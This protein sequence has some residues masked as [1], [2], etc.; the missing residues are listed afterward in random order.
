MVRGDVFFCFSIRRF[1]DLEFYVER[2]YFSVIVRIRFFL[3]DEV[4]FY[5]F[6]CDDG[7]F[8]RRGIF[9]FRDIGRGR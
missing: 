7:V 2:C 4:L 5:L 1:Y 8:Y 3:R 6:L 9:Y